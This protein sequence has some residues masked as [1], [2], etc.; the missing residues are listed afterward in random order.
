MRVGIMRTLILAIAVAVSGSCALIDGLGGG[1]SCQD[2]FSCFTCQSPF[3]VADGSTNVALCNQDQLF[4]FTNC[5]SF[6]G[7]DMV[8]RVDVSTAGNYEVCHNG[9]ISGSLSVSATSCGPD[10]VQDACLGVGSCQTVR[11]DPPSAFLTFRTDS[12][13]ECGRV[14]FSI[15]FRDTPEPLESGPTCLDGIDND[16]DTLVDCSDLD[17]RMD[18][19]TCSTGIDIELCNGVD[20]GDTAGFPQGTIDESAC[21]CVADAGCLEI[22]DPR[23]GTFICHENFRNGV[24]NPPCVPVMGDWCEVAG[25]LCG[26]SGNC[27]SP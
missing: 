9:G 26:I 8:F 5:G 12:P 3:L 2:D 16:A 15:M 22:N 24:C 17:C 4:P 6:D 21:R 10:D 27:T 14:D 19:A 1:S 18:D 13:N 23:L 11:M 25:G 20:D 7:D